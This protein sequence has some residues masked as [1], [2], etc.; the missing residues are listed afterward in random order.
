MTPTQWLKASSGRR[1]Y[2]ITR[3]RI[4]AAVESQ[5]FGLE[6]P[7]ICCNCGADHDSCEPDAREYTC[8]EC[9]ERAVFG[10]SELLFDVS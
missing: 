9:G 1:T 2:P 4:R 6:N 7:G 10:A 3:S 5:L 8:E